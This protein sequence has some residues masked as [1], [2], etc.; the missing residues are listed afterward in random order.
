MSKGLVAGFSEAVFESS[1]SQILRKHSKPVSDDAAI[2]WLKD[3]CA[4]VGEP[5]SSEATSTSGMLM[6]DNLRLKP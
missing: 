3:A 1:W 5:E 6:D 2:F 4:G